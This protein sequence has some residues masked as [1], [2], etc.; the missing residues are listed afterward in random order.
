M[1]KQILITRFLWLSAICNVVL[2]AMVV[3]IG[4]YK[5]NFVVSKLQRLGLVQKNAENHQDYWCIRGWTNTLEK[6]DLDVDVVFFGNSIT[7]GSDF[8]S[9]FPNVSICNLGYPGDNT[10]GMSFRAGQIRSVHPEKVF[11]MAGINGLSWQS[12]QLFKDNYSAMLDSIINAVPQAQIYVQSILPVNPNMGQNTYKGR[13][14]KIVRANKIVQE[15]AEQ[16]KCVYID[17]YTLYADKNGLMP[18]ELT[19]DG[20]HLKPSAYSIWADAI[21]QYI[22]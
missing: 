11:V 15:L 14:D 12:E 19:R 7:A 2:M 4:V 20:V 5:T 18:E 13:T 1:K 17:L 21:R 9:Y 16:R 6:L 3:Y 8:R 10:E 22:E